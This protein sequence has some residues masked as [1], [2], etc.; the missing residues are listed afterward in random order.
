M[1]A[2]P[3][4]HGRNLEEVRRGVARRE[5]ARILRRVEVPA[6]G[7]CPEVPGA[8]VRPEARTVAG[9]PASAPLPSPS[10]TRVRSH[11]ARAHLPASGPIWTP[12]SPPPERSPAEID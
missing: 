11:N 7:T 10:R 12:R 3:G 8:D 5:A 1:A 2:P 9:A 4:G 6:E